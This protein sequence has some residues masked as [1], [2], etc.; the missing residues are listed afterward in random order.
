[1]IKLK[2]TPV[3]FTVLGLLAF[4][5]FVRLWV[6]AGSLP[7]IWDLEAQIARLTR[8]NEEQEALNRQ[9]QSDVTELAKDDSAIED[10]ARSELGMI[11]DGESFYQIILREDAPQLIDQISNTP[12]PAGEGE[13]VE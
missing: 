8:L 4:M 11:K 10:H 2:M 7:E 9:L 3:L 1:M 6:G 13:H 12:K 5:L